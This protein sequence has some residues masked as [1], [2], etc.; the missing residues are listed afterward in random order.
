MESKQRIEYI[1]LMKGICI[2]LVV[3]GHTNVPEEFPEVFGVLNVIKIGRMPLYFFLSGLFFRTYSGFGDFAVRK[4]WNLIVPMLVFTVVPVILLRTLSPSV[5]LELKVGEIRHPLS[6]LRY[7]MFGPLWF[8]R[9]LFVALLVMYPIA[10]LDNGTWQ[11][12]LL[13]TAVAA[14]ISWLCWEVPFQVGGA[15]FG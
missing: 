3:I 9:A 15:L 6:F 1:D 4:F 5:A 13:L 2:I 7:N 10:R 8:L 12:R 11:R 14:L